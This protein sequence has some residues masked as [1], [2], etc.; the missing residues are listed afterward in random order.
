MVQRIKTVQESDLRMLGTL[1]RSIQRVLPVTQA[2]IDAAA[3]LGQGWVVTRVFEVADPLDNLR[4]GTQLVIRQNSIL[5]RQSVQRVLI[6]SGPGGET[7]IVRGSEYIALPD[8][9]AN[10]LEYLKAF[11]GTEQRNLPD[12][13]IERQFIYMM[14]G[15]YL[16]T[17]I[18]PTYDGH[19]ELDFQTTT[20]GSVA[21]AYIGGRTTSFP[22]GIILSH[23]SN[24]TVITDGFGERYDSSVEFLNNTRYKYVFDNKVFALYQAGTAVATNTFT[25]TDATGAALC[26]NGINT[27]GTIASNVEGIYLYGFKAW[28]NQ[29]QLIADYVPAVQRGTV[30]VVG[31]YDTVSGTFK[32]ATAGTFAA[33]GEAVPT[34]DA[35]MDIWCNNGVL[36]LTPNLYNPATDTIGSILTDGGA[37]SQG[38]Q[39]LVSDYI[40]VQPNTTYTLKLTRT[41]QEIYTRVCSYDSSKQFLSLLVKDTTITAGDIVATFTTDATASYIRV[42]FKNDSTNVMLNKGSSALPY[43]PY[44]ICADGTVETISVHSKNLLDINSSGVVSGYISSDGSLVTNTSWSVSD[45]IP[46][47][48]NTT[49]TYSTVRSVGLGSGAY[50]AYYDANYAFI[51]TQ[52]QG[53]NANK[54]FTT[55]AETA[56][57][58]VSFSGDENWQVELGSTATDYVPY[59]DG[60]TATAEMLLKVG[61][62]EDVQEILSGAITRS[63]RVKVLD[64]TENWMTGTGGVWYNFRGDV[65]AFNTTAMICSHYSYAGA[66]VNIADMS[67]NQFSSYSNGNIAFKSAETTS[68]ADFKTWL[69]DQYAAGT[70]VIIVY[71]RATPTTESVAGQTLQVTGGDNVV[72]ITQAALDGLELEAKYQAA[73]TL[74]IQEVQDANL[75]PNV[76]V[77]IN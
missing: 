62:Y 58:R 63:V 14:D 39:G 31:F 50:L 7:V 29:G 43:V 77:T 65:G 5:P 53:P 55:P 51:S 24:R 61:D 15:S 52:V 75:D 25:S 10:S 35:P 13:Y 49:F 20:V 34:P 67:Q 70:P 47:K 38:V 26:I 74:T 44:G 32:T 1:A 45:Y 57:I 18:V 33:G 19:Y 17:D 48:A 54:T 12:G 72:E 28:N 64:G 60:G 16:L 2:D 11:G 6:V 76:Q 27:N 73:V 4:G 46:I 9:I 71:P 23:G 21:A 40:L 68:G 56:Y 37:V 69:A 59:Y 3:A 42:S 41:A 36:K 66:Q 8:A 22:A 30:P